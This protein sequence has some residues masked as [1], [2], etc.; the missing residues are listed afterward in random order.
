VIAIGCLVGAEKLL[1]APDVADNLPA[2]VIQ[3]LPP[4]VAEPASL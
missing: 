2:V 4:S 3:D 1:S